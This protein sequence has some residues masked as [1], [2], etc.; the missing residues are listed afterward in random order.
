[1]KKLLGANGGPHAKPKNAKEEWVDASPE[2][3][4]D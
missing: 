3:S 1:M 4:H 2:S